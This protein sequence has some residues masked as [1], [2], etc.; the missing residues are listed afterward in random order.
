MQNYSKQKVKFLLDEVN[1]YEPHIQVSQ[2]FKERFQNVEG[3]RI[4]MIEDFKK[5][6]YQADMTKAYHIKRNFQ[7]CQQVREE[8][9]RQLDSDQLSEQVLLT[10]MEKVEGSQMATTSSQLS[11]DYRRF[12]ERYGTLQR[13]GNSKTKVAISVSCYN[14]RA[15]LEGESR[16]INPIAIVYEG[17]VSKF[18]KNFHNIDR[19][20]HSSRLNAEAK[21]HA[22]QAGPGKGG[23]DESERKGSELGDAEIEEVKKS[24]SGGGVWHEIGRTEWIPCNHHPVFATKVEI[25]VHRQSNQILKVRLLDMEI[26]NIDAEVRVDVEARLR[27]P[28]GQIQVSIE[29]LLKSGSFTGKLESCER[30]G[31]CFDDEEILGSLGSIQLDAIE[32]DEQMPS[33]DDEPSSQDEYFESGQRTIAQGADTGAPATEPASTAQGPLTIHEAGTDNPGSISLPELRAHCAENEVQE[34]E[35]FKTLC[36]MR[37]TARVGTAHKELQ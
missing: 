12:L 5:F 22:T 20:I 29:E 19:W 15:G 23:G 27:R 11:E 21:E 24:L 2:E 34:R 1:Y 37:V 13:F 31:S 7:N 16:T 36:G 30:G 26:E 35:N 4:S 25:P 8:I 9:H 6:I 18:P 3:S 32:M 14:L 10:K 28:I 17:A 33:I